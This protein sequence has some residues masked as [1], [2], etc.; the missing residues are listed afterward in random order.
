MQMTLDAK[1][2]RDADRAIARSEALPSGYRDFP[3]HEVAFWEF[4]AR[5]GSQTPRLNAHSQIAQDLWVA[6]L[7]GCWTERASGFF[8]EFGAFDGDALS[9]SYLFE[10]QFGW[11]GLLAE[12]IPEQFEACRRVRGCTID[13]RCVFSKSGQVLEFNCVRGANELGTIAYLDDQDGHAEN[14]RAREQLIEVTT[15]SL[16]DLLREHDAPRTI[17]YMSID[18]EGSELEILK[19]FDFS[20]HDIKI[21][22]IEH[23]YT[24]LQTALA[25]LLTR[26]GFFCLPRSGQYWDDIYLNAAHFDLKRLSERSAAA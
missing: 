10:K 20:R 22:S 23:N 1:L 11:T 16:N 12:P 18:T 2:A 17:D 25:Q 21:L 15:V 9:N 8:V 14:R 3:A 26:H 6:Y 7:L 24:D 5:V 13:P 4:Y 19:A